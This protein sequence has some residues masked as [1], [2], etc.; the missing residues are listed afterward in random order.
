MSQI[1]QVD[2]FIKLLIKE[3]E[4]EY[5]NK[6]YNIIKH[7]E[8]KI[9]ITKNWILAYIQY[10]DEECINDILKIKDEYKKSKLYISNI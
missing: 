6:I 1:K 4:N 5:L 2:K 3:N 7:H 9:T 10:F 8:C